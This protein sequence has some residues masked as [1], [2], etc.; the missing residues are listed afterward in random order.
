MKLFKLPD[1]G[2]G[3][4]DAEVREWYVKVGDEV[5]TDQPL[6]AME[7][8]KALVDVPAPFDGKVE[9]LF[10]APGDTIETGQPLIGFEGEDESEETKKDAGTVVGAIEEGEAV[11][12]ESAIG[13][14]PTKSTG[15]RIKATPAVRMLAKQLGVNLEDITPEGE[16]ITAE[17]V[18]RFATR[19]QTTPP[20]AKGPSLDGELTKLSN[21]RRAMVLSMTQSHQQI[22]PVTMVDDADTHTWS[23]NEDISL[24]IIRAIQAACET[25][26]IVNAYFDAEKM[27]YKQNETINLG[28]AVDTPNGLYVPVLKDISNRDDASLRE[29]INRFKEQAKNH[30]LPQED[31]RG[32]TIMMS[33]Y[34][35]FSGRYAT[36][37]PVPPMVAIIGI[38]RARDEVV[39]HNGKP[40]VH[41]IMPIAVSTDHRLVT[42]GE[43]GR[44]LKAL[45]DALEK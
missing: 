31:L 42:G 37:L 21:V 41:R 30:S 11:L 24:R 40:A 20:S 12:E 14:A 26:P 43:T 8:A 13:V 28:V 15:K 44:C 17:D 16:K 1:L 6:V 39:A 25:A 27:A 45:I 29:Q 38:G 5:K 34:G 35:T 10:G 23:D 2:E 33:N 7:T 18:K 9:K 32:A 36:P 4:P 22:V 3:L 19:G